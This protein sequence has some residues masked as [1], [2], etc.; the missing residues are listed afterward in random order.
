MAESLRDLR[1]D[2]D[3]AMLRTDA[4][5]GLATSSSATIR[6]SSAKLAEEDLLPPTDGGAVESIDAS[7]VK[8]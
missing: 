6:S 4:V 1:D 7:S 2:G 5:D 8:G 3:L